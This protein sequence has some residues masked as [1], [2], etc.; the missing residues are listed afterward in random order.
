MAPEKGPYEPP[1]VID[2]GSLSE[3]TG[4]V[5]NMGQRDNGAND[6]ASKT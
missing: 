5:N 3:L 1:A 6:S 4:G 2:L